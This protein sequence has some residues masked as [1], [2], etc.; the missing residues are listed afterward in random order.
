MFKENDNVLYV[1]NINNIDSNTIVEQIATQT[2]HASNDNN[3]SKKVVPA[4]T[5]TA[6]VALE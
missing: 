1:Y 2:N 4:S 5:A 6:A 3:S